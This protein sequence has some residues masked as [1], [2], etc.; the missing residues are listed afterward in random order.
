MWKKIYKNF[1]K[2]AVENLKVGDC[3]IFSPFCLHSSIPNFGKKI[4]WTLRYSVDDAYNTNHL[5][6]NL[7][8]FDKSKYTT[9]LTNDERRK[10]VEK[11][12][13]DG[14]TRLYT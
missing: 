8:I 10:L 6:K 3:L 14:N 2:I 13:T 5:D 12:I 11:K 1:K 9:D 4:R 7:H